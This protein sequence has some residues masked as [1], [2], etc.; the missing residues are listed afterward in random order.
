M[1]ARRS[2][3]NWLDLRLHHQST[4][5]T[6]MLHMTKTFD[7]VVLFPLLPISMAHFKA[8][9]DLVRNAFLNQMLEVMELDSG[10]VRLN[11]SV[12]EDEHEIY[13]ELNNR[14]STK[15]GVVDVGPTLARI[16]FQKGAVEMDQL[17]SLLLDIAGSGAPWFDE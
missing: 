17:S 11:W 9:L 13:Y 2:L 14:L 7:R 6:F 10:L 4:K 1:D 15:T 3:L 16:N 8:T 5:G 12:G